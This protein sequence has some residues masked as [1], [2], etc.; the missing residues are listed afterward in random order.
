MTH[1]DHLGIIERGCRGVVNF[2]EW[3]IYIAGIRISKEEWN[4]MPISR[5]LLQRIESNDESLRYLDFYRYGITNDDLCSLSQALKNNTTVVGINLGNTQVIA[6]IG[7]KTFPCPCDNNRDDNLDVENSFTAEGIEF[8]TQSCSHLEELFLNGT[9]IDD[10]VIALL[11]TWPKLKH[12]WIED[13]KKLTYVGARQ[14]PFFERLE[15][16]GDTKNEYLTQ[17]E[18]CL[19]DLHDNID[20]MLKENK[21]KSDPAY[22]YQSLLGDAFQCALDGKLED[23]QYLVGL[24]PQGVHT[25]EL[26]IGD[27]LLH[28]A[29]EKGHLNV[30]EYLLAQGAIV[31]AINLEEKTPLFLAAEKGH[32][33]MVQLLLKHVANTQGEFR[34]N[35]ETP[36]SIAYFKFC[37]VIFQVL[38]LSNKNSTREHESIRRLVLRSKPEMELWS[39]LFQGN[40][41]QLPPWIQFGEDR[42]L[43]VKFMEI[44]YRYFQELQMLVRNNDALN[45]LTTQ[46]NEANDYYTIVQKMDE[47]EVISNELPSS[48]PVEESYFSDS[49]PS[50]D[51]DTDEPELS[52]GYKRKNTTLI[53]LPRKP[54]A[55]KNRLDKE[56]LAQLIERLNHEIKEGGRGNIDWSKYPTMYIA[57]YRGVHY[58]RNKFTA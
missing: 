58:Y 42:L 25:R 24:L 4:L 26:P 45:T 50:D 6:I 53:T 31:E 57:Q 11:L 14:L 3:V 34:F 43:R 27:S 56:A 17:I 48:E 22:R 47:I 12:L 20:N 39:E 35:R 36:Y 15:W 54:Q 13:C 32:W 18:Y 1:V 52:A 9:N 46:L 40:T 28:C 41:T 30:A 44:A 23:L 5:T 51:S 37:D 55:E 19:S 8:L 10:G 38:R 21:K 49:P 33:R 29:A 16:L 7:R 2:S